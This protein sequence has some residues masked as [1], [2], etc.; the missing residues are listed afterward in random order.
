MDL[1]LSNCI[2]A[3]EAAASKAA[4]GDI[5]NNKDTCSNKKQKPTIPKIGPANLL[6]MPLGAKLPVIPGSN[7]I[8]YTTNISEKLFQPSF[9]FNLS[10]PYCKLMETTYKSLHDPH[11]KSYFKRKD[12]LKKLKKEG[13]ITGNNKVVCSLKEL[14]KYRQYLTT[15]KID[16]E[17]NYVREQKIIENQVNKLNEERRAYDNAAAAEFQWWL[18]QEGKKA[19][20]QHERLIKLRHLNMINKELDKLEDTVGK[21]SSLVMKEEDRQH[22]DDVKRKLNL[23]QEVE[24]DW[25]F[26]EMSL[27]TKIGDEVKR[28]TKVEEHHRKIREEINR[29]KQ[30]MLQ[31]RIAY[32]LQKLQEKESKEG[33]REESTSESKRPSE[34]ASS[35]QK[36]PSFTEPKM[37]QEHLER[38]TSISSMRTSISERLMQESRESKSISQ[39]TRTSFDEDQSSLYKLLETRFSPIA[40]RRSSLAEDQAFQE[41]L[42]PKYRHHSSGKKTSFAE[43]T[44]FHEHNEQ[45]Y[46]PPNTKRRSFANDKFMEDLLEAKYLYQ[47]TKRTS[48]TDQKPMEDNLHSILTSPSTRRTSVSD[49]RMFYE[50]IQ[51]KSPPIIK[52]TSFAEEKSFQQLMEAI[53][54]PQYVKKTS[55]SDQRSSQESLETRRSSHHSQNNM[56]VFVKTST[57]LPPQQRGIQNTSN[58]KYDKGSSRTSHHSHDR[59]PDPSHC[60]QSTALSRQP[61]H[62]IPTHEVDPSFRRNT[63]KHSK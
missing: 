62:D 14:N 16:F 39:T 48:F 3:A 44:L 27:M 43:E 50:P 61:C 35:I 52:K 32:H 19:S 9:G 22:W 60:L 37:S 20:P 36:Q 46:D 21:R 30:V 4:S 12:I 31:K 24:A 53:M 63:H 25:Q 47:N 26:K 15:L 5:T 23:H 28:E 49:Q 7:S 13:Y 56:K 59:A 45:K 55:I 29:K 2:K 11:L 58:H 40:R 33:K 10:D 54:P 41:V 34:T 57:T 6:D 8:F 17:R 42:E 1:Y 18:L 38:K 51:I